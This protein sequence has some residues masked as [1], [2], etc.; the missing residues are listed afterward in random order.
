MNQYQKYLLELQKSQN[1][2]EL[3]VLPDYSDCQIDFVSNDYLGLGQIKLSL[4]EFDT[5]SGMGSRLIAGNSHAA[6]DC[7]TFLADFYDAES[8][9]VFNSGYT[10]NLGFFST[11]PKK[12][13]VVLYDELVHASIRDGLRLS[14][15]SAY[16]F[17]HNDWS[18]LE[19]KLVRNQDKTIFVVIEACYSMHG[20]F[21]DLE[22]IFTLAE[23]YQCQIIVD[24][25]HSIGV[26]GDQGKGLSFAFAQ[27]PQLLARIIT[28]GKALGAHGAAVLCNAEVKSYLI[29][30]CRAFIY[31]TALPPEQYARIQAA[32][33]HCAAMDQEREALQVIC[34]YFGERTNTHQRHIQTILITDIERI[35]KI[36]ERA[37]QHKIALKGVWSPTV[38]PG[39]ERLRI[40]LH[41][42]NTTQEIDALLAL[43]K[44][45]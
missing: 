6:Q 35:K 3:R 20:D 41:S 21:A 24:E 44:E 15:A 18:D 17:K 8:A 29:H 43:L 40:S 11:V 45:I 37:K 19:S 4:P 31:T 28:F 1:Y 12:D 38:P 22:S 13:E 32:V 39:Q 14:P 33:Q 42:S 36:V 7:E 16:A 34:K 27:H 23:Q 25:A 30:A 5:H 26:C 2:G 10:T 9:L